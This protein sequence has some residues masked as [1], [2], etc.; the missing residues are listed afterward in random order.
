MPD[1]PSE[2]PSS[3]R[4]VAASNKFTDQ[5]QVRDP[6]H[7][8]IAPQPRYTKQAA[9]ER[10][11]V[12]CERRLLDELDWDLIHFDHLHVAVSPNGIFHR[13]ARAARNEAKPH[14]AVRA[15]TTMSVPLA[16]YSA[17][18]DLVRAQPWG[19][20]R[21]SIVKLG[22]ADDERLVV[23]LN[24]AT[25]RLY[26]LSGDPA[27]FSLGEEVKDSG[28][29]SAEIW[30]S[31]LAVLTKAA[32]Q[33]V[34]L[35][36]QTLNSVKM[37]SEMDYQELEFPP[38]QHIRVSPN[39]NF[40]AS[41]T[42]GFKL[43]LR[44]APSMHLTSSLDLQTVVDCDLNDF[45]DLA[46]VF[47]HISGE[48]YVIDLF[49]PVILSP[50]LESCFQI[51]ST[52]VTLFSIV[53]YATQ[54]IFKIGSTHPRGAVLMDAVDHY[55]RKAAQS[56]DLLEELLRTAQLRG[57]L[58]TCLESAIQ[59][60]EP[61]VQRAL[62]TAVQFGRVWVASETAAV[63]GTPASSPPR[64]ASVDAAATASIIITIR[65]ALEAGGRAM[66]HAAVNASGSS[67]EIRVPR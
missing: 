15:T 28:I 5:R 19:R 62:L 48:H 26:P 33:F 30:P 35:V 13:F 6:A 27:V 12:L 1:T 37:V 57:A 24:D 25:V 50:A 31:G 60:W 22:W 53:P 55:N 16:I 41:V 23:L 67:P 21:A 64:R 59:A 4:Q 36:A 49:E 32:N 63:A 52:D 46:L 20:E 54:N 65:D 7:A 10:G 51:T 40:W 47:F 43:E 17:K 56:V 42:N 34:P 18:G 61:K 11:S 8:A 9:A 66:Q 39:A 14:F 45:D 44:L 29:H 58:T 3:P 2:F 38:L